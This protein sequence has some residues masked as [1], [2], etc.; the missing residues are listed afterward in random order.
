MSDEPTH[1][2]YLGDAPGTRKTYAIIKY[3]IELY[4]L[5]ISSIIAEPSLKNQY[6]VQKR[7]A[8]V[9]PDVFTV[10][11]NIETTSKVVDSINEFFKDE[12]NEEGKPKLE[13]KELKPMILIVT[14]SAFLL[15]NIKNHRGQCAVFFDEKLSLKHAVPSVKLKQ[16]KNLITHFM[17]IEEDEYVSSISEIRVKHITQL[18]ELLKDKDNDDVTNS[19]QDYYSMLLKCANKE[20]ILIAETKSYND[21]IKDDSTQS[22]LVYG[23]VTPKI[24]AGFFQVTFTCAYLESSFWFNC[25]K[26]HFDVV[27]HRATHMI[28]WLSVPKQKTINLHYFVESGLWSKYKQ[29]QPLEDGRQ[30]TQVLVDEIEKHFGHS[31]NLYD[32]PEYILGLVNKTI[33]NNELFG[34]Q[35]LANRHHIIQCP[36]NSSGVNEY[37]HID[38][39]FSVKSMNANPREYPLYEKFGLKEELRLME[40]E[41]TLQAFYRTSIREPDVDNTVTGIVVTK[42]LAEEMERFLIRDGHTVTVSKIALDESINITSFLEDGRNKTYNTKLTRQQRY[43]LRMKLDGLAIKEAE[44]KTNL[45][46]AGMLGKDWKGP[47]EEVIK[48]KLLII[49]TEMKSAEQTLAD[50]KL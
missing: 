19:L 49:T 24:F 12:L 47:S 36:Q 45:E 37:R 5:G 28:K 8:A 42:Y 20:M 23:L 48:L 22:C 18:K 16:N 44:W 14:H 25:W 4:H 2:W 50:N 15:A 43:K 17:K 30:I 38:T 39:F 40:V 7:I 10:L 1:F 26:N 13:Q 46:A 27:W 34:D 6:E 3:A 29:E 21:F 32:D 41:E 9:N 11:I 35:L 33:H 31:G